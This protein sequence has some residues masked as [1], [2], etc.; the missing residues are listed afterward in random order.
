MFNQLNIIHLRSSYTHSSYRKKL[1]FFLIVKA[2]KIT[3]RK[4][5]LLGYF[6]LFFV[7]NF[8]NHRLPNLYKFFIFPRIQP[9][10][11]TKNNKSRQ[12]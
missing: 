6:E 8:E 2:E 9:F 3:L 7:L 5:C 12:S 11:E 1:K 4:T 10:K